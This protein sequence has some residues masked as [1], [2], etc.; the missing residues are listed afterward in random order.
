MT[1]NHDPVMTESMIVCLL[2]DDAERAM[3]GSEV[4]WCV[5]CGSEICV[6]PDGLELIDSG[7]A[8]PVCIDCGS[9]LAD[10]DEPDEVYARRDGVDVPLPGEATRAALHLLREQR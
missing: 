5:L 3:P 4:R 10:L 6:S 9:G 2:W 1:K 7:A 8:R